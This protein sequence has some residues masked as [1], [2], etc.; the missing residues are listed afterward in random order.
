M[1][2]PALGEDNVS[3]WVVNDNEVNGF[4][5]IILDGET[6]GRIPPMQAFFIKSE[7]AQPTIHFDTNMTVD[8]DVTKG[9]DIAG[10]EQNSRI[11]LQVGK[12]T[13]SSS[14]LILNADASQEFD[15]REDTELLGDDLLSDVPAVYTVASSRAVMVNSLPEIY[16]VPLGVVAK[17]SELMSLNVQGAGSLS[18]PLYLYDAATRKYQEIKDGEEV[19]AQANEHGRYFLTQTRNATGIEDAEMGEKSVKIDSPARGLIVVS[20]IGAP[21]LNK[22]EVY[23]LDGRLVASRKAEGAASV[24]IPV[25]SLS[26]SSSSS[27]QGIYI[28]K[29]SVMDTH[30]TITR[31]LSLR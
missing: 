19:K 2:N 25:S 14:Y 24:S 29:V 23:T 8:K 6:D 27:S 5:T 21:L 15:G 12:G 3:Y 1:G 22:V 13:A 18:S 10:E 17:K 28:I 30:A 16:Y 26:S 7:T 31:K 4:N 9:V 11:R 20:K